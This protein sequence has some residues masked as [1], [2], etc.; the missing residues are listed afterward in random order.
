LCVIDGPTRG[1]PWSATAA[2]G[3]LRRYAAA[4]G[5]R[6]SFAPH[7]YADSLGKPTRA[8]ESQQFG[9]IAGL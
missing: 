5:V 3:E 9:L 4:A 1:R 6:R 7:Q 8:S 2:R